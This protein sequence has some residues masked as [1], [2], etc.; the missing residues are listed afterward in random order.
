V[1]LTSTQPNSA[2]A[3]GGASSI[4][5]QLRAYQQQRQ[6]DVAQLG[7]DLK[8][9]DLQAAQQDFNTLT[10]LGQSGP[11]KNGQAFQQANRSQ[12]FQAIG[13]ALQSGDLTGAQ[14]AFASLESTLTERIP[15]TSPTESASGNALSVS[16]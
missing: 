4:Y 6:A 10:L 3:S 8:A 14:S 9:G 5:Q 13:Q 2:A 16:A 11:N 7:K 1:N 12:A 15:S